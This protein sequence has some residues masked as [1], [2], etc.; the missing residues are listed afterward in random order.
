MGGCERTVETTEVLK[1]LLWTASK[2]RR[3][4]PSP[5]NSTAWSMWGAISKRS[6]ASSM[7]MLPLILRR[8]EAS[9][10]SL[11]GLVIMV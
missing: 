1:P 2:R 4:S 6:T 7:S 11:V 3:K 5:E 9:V 10:N 8:P